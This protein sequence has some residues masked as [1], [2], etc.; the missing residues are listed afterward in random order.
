MDSI[1][2]DQT[3]FIGCIICSELFSYGSFIQD[4]LR[5]NFSLYVYVFQVTVK[6]VLETHFLKQPKPTAADIARLSDELQ[7]EKEV[8]RVWFCNRRQKEKRM[9]P[10]VAVAGPGGELIQPNGGG[11]CPGD[12]DDDDDDDDSAGTG[13]SVHSADSPPQTLGVRVASN[14]S[15]SPLTAACYPQ[16]AGSCSPSGTFMSSPSNGDL[17]TSSMTNCH[18]VIHSSHTQ[19]PGVGVGLGIGSSPSHV[20]MYQHALG[21]AGSGSDITCAGGIPQRHQLIGATPHHQVVQHVG[22]IMTSSRHQQMQQL[23]QLQQQQQY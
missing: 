15:G 2:L 9:T 7:L 3:I 6:G 10:V 4:F 8:V 11:S 23:P 20:L 12:A 19:Q 5:I 14:G 21:V 18:S 1:R 13:S 16:Q 17:V 22:T